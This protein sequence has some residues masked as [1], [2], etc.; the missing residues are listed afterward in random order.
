MRNPTSL[1]ALLVAVG[2]AF[3]AYYGDQLWRFE[4]KTE[5]QVQELLQ[6]RLATELVQRGEHMR[7][8]G[9]K[10]LRLVRTI[11]TE[12]RAEDEIAKKDIER[13]LGIGL[14]VLV[15]GLGQYVFVLL[16]ERARHK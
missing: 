11:E 14:F 13:W 1:P 12:V 6:I 10:L 8:Q 4:P 7:P 5:E 15:I 3:S 16:G 2:L 9:E